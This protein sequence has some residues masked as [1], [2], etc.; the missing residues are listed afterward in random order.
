MR[1]AFLVVAYAA[2]PSRLLL[3]VMRSFL[4]ARYNE[5]MTTIAGPPQKITDLIALDM[6]GVA[7]IAGSRIKV[8]H[9]AVEHTR[10]GLTPEQIVAVYPHLTLN[11]VEAALSHYYARRA[12]MEDQIAASDQFAD[13]M[14]AEAGPSPVAARLRAQG[15]LPRAEERHEHW[16]VRVTA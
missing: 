15:M 16:Q 2:C 7:R 4:V 8:A 5:N 13:K 9:L 14:R 10:D 6:E 12:D 1:R 3:A 11:Q